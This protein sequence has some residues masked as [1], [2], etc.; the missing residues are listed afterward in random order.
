M[1]LTRPLVCLDIES[2]GPRPDADRIVELAL[3]VLR[4]D[5][6]R[7]RHRWLVN[8]GCSIPADATAVHGYT[9]AGVSTAPRFEAIAHDVAP[10]L[11]G[12]DL[13]GYNLRAFDL[14]ILRAEFERAGVAWPCDGARVVDSFVIFRERE[15]HTLST[16]VRRYCGRELMDAHSA[17]ADADATL[18]VVLAQVELYD[19]LRGLDLAALDVAS[20]GQRPD[21]ATEFGHL[22]WR[23]DGDLYIAFGK[24]E[25]RRLVDLDDG[26]L[27]WITG[28]DFPADV[29]DLVWA[30]RRG[31]R[32]RAPGAPSLEE[33]VD[34]D[35]PDDCDDFFSC[36]QE[37]VG[38]NPAPCT[39]ASDDDIPF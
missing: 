35:D 15:R 23:D 6:S 39:P 12:V 36:A 27:R 34:S 8:P 7:D 2:T 29:K 25:G 21:W 33:R 28:K 38:L 10:L 37:P 30:V 19:D 20:G 1:N 18:D 14:P 3:V 17:V 26:F 22:R 11:R 32:P 16:A 24:H 4:P 9:D 13:T 5:G 31:E